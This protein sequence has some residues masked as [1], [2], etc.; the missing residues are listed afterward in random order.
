MCGVPCGLPEK[1][2]GR[3]HWA[4][5][6]C[7]SHGGDSRCDD[8]CGV[9]VCSL[10]DWRGTP[11]EVGSTVVYSSGEKFWKHQVEAEVIEL[12]VATT[13]Y[14]RK[15]ARVKALRRSEPANDSGFYS[16]GRAV[17]IAYNRMTVIA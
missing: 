8:R 9:S 17:N 7:A 15:G 2:V 10:T 13:G 1:L 5:R 11:L 6:G 12:D 14:G 16:T 4:Y 3:P